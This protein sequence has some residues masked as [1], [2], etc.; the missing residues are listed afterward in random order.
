MERKTE[1][2]V[3]KIYFII[4]GL[5]LILA[6]LVMNLHIIPTGYTGVTTRFGQIDDRPVHSGRLYFTMPLVE[7][8]QKVNNKQQ[9]FYI[10]EQI[11]GETNDK[12]PVYG[13][14]IYITYQILPERSAW[15]YANV[16]D[17]TKNLL[18][19]SLIASAMKS[20]MVELS[21]AD[22][23]NRTKVEPMVQEKLQESLDGKYGENTIY[24]NKVVIGDMDFEEAYN[25]AIQQRSI[26]LQE[27]AKS[28]IENQTSIARAEAEKQVAVLKAEAEAES[29]KIAAEAEAA[30]NKLIEES[31]SEV[32]MLYK[33]VESWDGKLPLVLGGGDGMMVDISQLLKSGE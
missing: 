13:R 5:C 8:I 33:V 16:S 23:T 22:V 6:V 9:E 19:D 25:A 17:Y 18:T 10:K 26:A 14:D 31:L 12:T 20:A 2:K 32:L 30:A 4:A 24:V 3:N 21:P 15:I 1:R 28:E 7:S 29:I 27:Q 11:W